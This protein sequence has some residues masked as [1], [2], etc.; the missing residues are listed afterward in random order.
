MYYN[1][2]ALGIAFYSKYTRMCISSCYYVYFSPLQCVNLLMRQEH[3][4]KMVHVLV[5]LDGLE[6]SVTCQVRRECVCNLCFY[7]RKIINLLNMLS[8]ICVLIVFKCS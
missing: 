5:V 3:V 6:M 1:Y 7:L 2:G 8:M 4:L